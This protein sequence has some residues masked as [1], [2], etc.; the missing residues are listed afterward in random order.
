MRGVYHREISI[1]RDY[2]RR[3]NRQ[4]AHRRP[5]SVSSD[6]TRTKVSPRLCERSNPVVATTD[7]PTPR[8]LRLSKRPRGFLRPC[9]RACSV[10][11]VR[12]RF[13]VTACPCCCIPVFEL[14]CHY[15]CTGLAKLGGR[16][17]IWINE[18]PVSRVMPDLSWVQVRI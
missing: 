13:A 5:H 9:G 3:E 14:F 17:I 11:R 1:N 4:E 18:A 2:C 7:T 16:D 8:D 6:S 10:Y 15:G 12:L